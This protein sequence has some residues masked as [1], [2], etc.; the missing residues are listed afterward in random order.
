M[1]SA[2]PIL[3]DLNQMENDFQ[4]L[5]ELLE[6]TSKRE[7][8]FYTSPKEI[9]L[10]DFCQQQLK[11]ILQEMQFKLGR[12]INELIESVKQKTY[13]YADVHAQNQDLLMQISELKANLKN[14]EKG[15]S[16][17]TKFDKAHVSK[18]LL[19]VT[20]LNKQVFQKKIVAPKIEKKHVLSKI[21]TLQTLPNKQQAVGTNENVIAPGMYKIGTSQLINTNKAKIVLSSTG[22]SATS[23]V[24]RSSN[25]DSSLKNSVVS[26]TKNSSK[27]VEVSDRINIK[28]DVAS[29][30]VALNKIV[31]N[32]EIKNALIA[33][34]V[35]CVSC[36]KNVLIPCHDNCLAKYKL[37]DIISSVLDNSMMVIWKFLFAQ[38]H[39]MYEL[40]GDY[41]LTGAREY[42]LYTISILDMATSSPVCLMSKATLTKSWLWHRKD[43]LCSTCERG[44]SKKASH[45]PKLVSSSHSN[46]ELLP[47]DLW[48]KLRVAYRSM[49]RA[50]STACFTQNRSII[51]K[52]HNKTPYELLRGRKP[53]VEYFNVFGSL[54]YP[55]ND[56]DDLGKMKL[57]EDIDSM[58]TLSK[59]DLDDLFEAMYDEYF[60]KKTRGSSIV[61]SSDETTAPNLLKRDLSKVESSTALDPSNMHEFHQV[62]PSTYI[63]I[64]AHSL[65]Q[66]IGDPSKPLMTRNR[67][68]TDHE[69]CMYALTVSIN[70]TK[71][72]NEVMSDHNDIIFG[73]IKK[74]LCNAFEKLMHEKFQMSSMGELTFFLGLQVKQKNDVIFISQDKY[75]PEILKKFGFTKVKTASTPM[76][77]QKP[78]LKDED[79][80]EVDVHLYRSMIGS[81]IYLTSLRPDI[82]FA[83]CA[84]ARYQVNPKV[85]HLH[86]VKRIFR[87][88]KGQL[89]LGLW[90]LKDSPFDLVAYTNSDYAGASLDMKSTIGGKAKKCVR[91]CGIKTERVIWFVGARETPL[92]PYNDGTRSRRSRSRRSKRKDTQVPQS[93]IPSDNV[94]DAA[95]NEEMDD[96][97]VRVAT[98][99]T[100]LDAEQ[101]RGN[102]DKTQ[103]KATLNEPSSLGTCSGSGPRRQETM[104]DTIAQTRSENASKLSNDPLLARG[105]T[106]RSGEDILKL[107]ELMALCKT[108]QSRVLALETT[109]TTQATEIASLKK[110]VKKLERRNK[111]RTYGLK[112]LYRVGS[113]RTLTTTTV[114]TTIT[115]VSTRPKAK[116]LVIHK[117]EQAPTPT[118]S[119]QPPSRVKVLDKL[120]EESS[121]KAEIEQEES[122]K[123]AKAEMMEMVEGLEVLWSIVKARFKK[124]EPVNYMHNFLLL[125]LKTIFEHHVEDNGRIVG[126]KSLLEVTAAKLMLLVYKL[127]LL[128][129]KV[130]AASTKVTTTQRLRLLK[131]FLLYA[132]ITVNPTIYTSCIEQFWS[133]VKAKTINGEVQLHALVDGKKIIITECN[134]RRDLQLA[135]EEGVDCLPNSTIFEQLALM[136]KP[137]RKN[138]QVPQSSDPSKNVIDEAIHKELGDSLVRAATTAS[139]LEAEQDSG[140]GPWCQETM[141][142]TIAQ[143]KFENVS[144]HSN[145]SLLARDNEIASLKRRVNKLEKKRSSRTHKLKRLYKFGLTARVE[146]SRDEESLGE[147]ASK[148]GRINAIDADEEITLVNVQDDADNEMFDVNVLGSEEVFVAGQNENVVEEVVDAAQV[149]TVATIVTITTEEIT[150]AQALEALKTSKPKVKGI[151]F[152]KPGKSTTTT[153]ISSQQSQD[154]G[155][156]I[157]IEEPVKPMKKKDQISFDEETTLK[158]QAKFDEEERLAR[159]KAEKEEEANSALIE[160]WDDIQAKINA[161]H[162]L[163]ER[164]QAQEQEK[165]SVK[166]KAT[167]FQQLL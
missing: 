78:L 113:S 115:A 29:Q 8:I 152:Q 47:M 137:K 71:N 14:V 138:T 144:K 116:G 59:E 36:A 91:L 57:K 64:K 154:K 88:L 112:R 145:D 45:P 127:L 117:Q 141:G 159:E 13:A 50:V 110:R 79:G 121:K 43:H 153:T 93:C 130:N 147:D 108:L 34:N 167:L 142:D 102:I 100:S 31:T 74:E 123:K 28:P 56:R 133:T 125:N 6:T 32:D 38:Q 2:N 156:G 63:W 15:K 82:M 166:E 1:P 124:T 11:P 24:R 39:D 55:T 81:L 85:S 67:I 65:K 21:V 70:V 37:N 80:E 10:N 94:A 40:E 95:V 146:S 33:K 151:V 41:L 7:S 69:V 23:S 52:R 105:N 72:I 118:V 134:V 122:S 87:Y 135:N 5:F 163:V 92:F 104:G 126:V 148:Q 86:D 42:N 4:K 51:H 84:C 129:L 53:N 160:E 17:N 128:V 99:A 109:K 132:L 30:N 136:G 97:L 58:N 101:D 89:K 111:L 62:Q 161:D 49:E 19:C 9:R 83:V 77:T 139:S 20:P 16:V 106:L 140:G 68:K 60:K 131:E 27:T 149:S 164:L 73:S 54:C 18:N 22:L 90:Y 48:D 155:K 119:S 162:Q 76:E 96:S 158:L 157:M 46:L 98:T 35:L 25:R 26:N 103:S 12:E 3:V 61:S 114:A 120:V 44:K 107:E 143:T 165:L 150:L 75:V 66:V